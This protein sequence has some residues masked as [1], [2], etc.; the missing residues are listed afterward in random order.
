[1]YV[2]GKPFV[3]RDH[4]KP[5]ANLVNTGINTRRLEAQ[6][7]QLVKDALAESAKFGGKILLHDEVKHIH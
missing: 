6:E 1:M 5:Y 4:D 2:N 7:R 3:L